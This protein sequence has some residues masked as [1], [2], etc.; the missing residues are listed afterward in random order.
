MSRRVRPSDP[1]I[2][3]ADARFSET[4]DLMFFDRPTLGIPTWAGLAFGINTPLAFTFVLI[5][6]E[7]SVFGIEFGQFSFA[8]VS[9]R[10]TVTDLFHDFSG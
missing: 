3:P 10:E 7:S 6:I 4:L 8:F 5:I 2:D 1:D 9:F